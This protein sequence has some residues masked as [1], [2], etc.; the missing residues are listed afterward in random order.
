MT[1]LVPV[2][3]DG[4]WGWVVVV[5]SFMVH[6]LADGFVYS[7]GVLVEELVEEFH[8]SS[9]FVAV[10]LSLLTGLTLG[11]GPV[12]SAVTDKYGCR[13]STIV[14]SCI[15]TVG[16]AITFFATGIPYICV[17][18]GC[19]MGVGIGL[20]Y[21][22]AI[23]IVTMYF[24]K[25]RALATGV[26]VSGAG[27]GTWIFPQIYGYIRT[28]FG[29]RYV[30]LF[31]AGCM[32]ICGL[33][34]A[35]FRPLQFIETDDDEDSAAK[36]ESS[37]KEGNETTKESAALLSPSAALKATSNTSLHSAGR[38]LNAR[39]SGDV[40]DAEQGGQR[41]RAGTV[42]EGTGYLSVK[43]VLYT[44]SIT[45]VAEFKE[46]PDKYRHRKVTLPEGIPTHW[47][48]TTSLHCFL[49]MT[50][51]HSHTHKASKLG[52][53]KEIEGDDDVFEDEKSLERKTEGGIWNSAVRMLNLDLLAE[54]AFVLF[55]VSNLLTSVGFNSP[56]YFLPM[57][58]NKGLGLAKADGDMVLSVF[59]ICNTV[60]RITFGLVGDRKLPFLPFGWGDD[61]ARNRLWIYNLSLSICGLL[62]C[63][64]FV[65]DNYLLLCIYSGTFGFTISSYI[66][67][68]SVILVDLLGLERLTNAFGLLLLFQGVG[69]VFGP[70]LSGWLADINGNNY[71]YSFFFC[72]VNLLVSGVM[73]FM[74]PCLRKNKPAPAAAD[75]KRPV[76]MH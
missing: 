49:S 57:H 34:G 11:C 50:S 13:I 9:A 66:C 76:M 25:R 46:N 48:S 68:T 41:S 52:E 64:S 63:L 62:T 17:T 56:L 65:F 59:G 14:G 39:S 20:M 4:G 16:C 74:T 6:V 72:G 2:I 15:A 26:A 3:P 24:E 5:G 70:P 73:M 60:G 27:I 67:L 33:C 43:G 47:N 75:G 21:C 55:A 51:L 18:V 1:R 44:G 69:T 45:D 38:G 30:F 32:A 19:I 53:L 31:G 71:N 54:P 23:V 37:V 8:A 10:I 42:T 29:W 35:T 61:T 28:A 12:A 40:N 36:S 22:P 7:F 58:A